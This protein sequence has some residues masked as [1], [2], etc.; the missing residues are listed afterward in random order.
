VLSLHI[1]G[2]LKHHLINRDGVLA[3]M[4]GWRRKG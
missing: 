1:I 2:A 3:R 4:A